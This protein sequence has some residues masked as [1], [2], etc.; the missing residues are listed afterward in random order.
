MAAGRCAT[1]GRSI[2]TMRCPIRIEHAATSTCMVPENW[3][4]LP[5]FFF[6]TERGI[7][8]TRVFVSALITA[9]PNRYYHGYLAFKPLCRSSA[10]SD[11]RGLATPGTR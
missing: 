4:N 3:S 5:F 8:V 9:Q 2:P 11:L 6:A 1:T 10:L 7:I